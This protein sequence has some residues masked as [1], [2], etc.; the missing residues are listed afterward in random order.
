MNMFD[1]I[2]MSIA[3]FLEMS[4]YTPK[5]TFWTDFSIADKF[6]VKAVEDTYN[7]A[8]KEWKSNIE[9]VTELVMV[10]NWKSWQYA[11]TNPDLAM[12]YQRLWEKADQWCMNNLKGDDLQYFI[13][14]LD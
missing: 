12:V 2:N 6:G 1:E 8:F 9:Y 4:G 11:E 13:K 14:T 7:R 10:L 3:P 5:T